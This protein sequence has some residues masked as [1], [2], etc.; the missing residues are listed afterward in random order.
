M[1]RALNPEGQHLDLKHPPESDTAQLSTVAQPIH[2]RQTPDPQQTPD[3]ILTPMAPAQNRLVATQPAGSHR[4]APSQL[5]AAPKFHLQPRHLSP[6]QDILLIP[7]QNKDICTARV[8]LIYI[9]GQGSTL[10]STKTQR[11]NFSWKL[12]PPTVI[13]R[14][15]AV[16]LLLLE[17]GVEPMNTRN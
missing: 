5:Q 3:C 7:K 15:H 17:A 1:K 9:S 14:T 12:R 16:R 11:T 10:G 6:D 8:H 2:Q 4:A 13:L